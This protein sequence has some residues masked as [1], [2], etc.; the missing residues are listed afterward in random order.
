MVDIH[1]ASM[2]GIL[3]VVS[4]AG[5]VI[6]AT[7]GKFQGLLKLYDIMVFWL[8]CERLVLLYGCCIY[9]LLVITVKTPTRTFQ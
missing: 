2:Y 6:P 5:V 3:C 4:S 1:G 8:V 9:K 7:F